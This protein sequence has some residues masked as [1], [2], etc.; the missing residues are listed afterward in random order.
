MDKKQTLVAVLG[1]TCILAL[2]SLV[3]PARESFTQRPIVDY[4]KSMTDMRLKLNK[5]YGTLKQVRL[6]AMDIVNAGDRTKKLEKRVDDMM[7]SNNAKIAAIELKTMSKLDR[8]QFDADGKMLVCDVDG[9]NCETL[10]P[11]VAPL[12]VTKV[13]VA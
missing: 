6:N 9:S 10:G 4:E 5:V 1:A 8:I 13:D 7:V 11:V 3:C 12:P 2:M